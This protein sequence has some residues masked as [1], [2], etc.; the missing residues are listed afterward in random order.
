MC[1]SISLWHQL[2]RSIRVITVPVPDFNALYTPWKFW[3]SRAA[4]CW[5]PDLESVTH[6]TSFLGSMRILL[7]EIVK[8]AFPSRCL[9]TA[10]WRVVRVLSLHQH[11]LRSGATKNK[12]RHHEAQALLL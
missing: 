12:R 8:M 9:Q 3:D 2:H 10:L 4:P 6:L 7:C 5:N 11:C 1:E